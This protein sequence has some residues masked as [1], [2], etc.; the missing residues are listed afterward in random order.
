MGSPTSIRYSKV[1]REMMIMR[2]WR[3]W[4]VLWAAAL[5]LYQAATVSL[6]ETD[7]NPRGQGA[8]ASTPWSRSVSAS[9]GKRILLSQVASDSDISPAAKAVINI[10]S[11]A[12]VEVFGAT[13][14]GGNLNPFSGTGWIIRQTEY[15]TYVLTNRH[16]VNR[17][18]TEA[19]AT[20]RLVPNTD[21]S[22]SPLGAT[23]NIAW[24]DI[25]GKRL[26]IAGTIV[27]TGS[28]TSGVVGDTALIRVDERV[29]VEA[30]PIAYLSDDELVERSIYTGGYAAD[31]QKPGQLKQLVISKNCRAVRNTDDGFLTTC[32][33]YSGNSGGWAIA[34][35]SIDSKIEKWELIGMPTSVER[36]ESV[37]P[38]PLSGYG[39]DIRIINLQKIQNFLSSSVR[40]DIKRPLMAK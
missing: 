17:G 34:N 1:L 29:G 22:A 6:A 31:M 27:R 19:E 40:A 30:P 8:P 16:I 39:G 15:S 23:V 14:Q 11:L 26:V 4:N 36:R 7:T 2:H 25:T 33:G 5:G 24:T 21:I 13:L 3:S 38:E 37:K 28:F 20:G 10:L 32:R 12:T 18:I 9:E 35:T